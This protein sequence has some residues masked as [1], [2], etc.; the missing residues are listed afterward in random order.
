MDKKIEFWDPHFH[1]WDVRENT[2]TGQELAELFAPN[3]D[4]V[5]AIHSYEKDCDTGDDDIEPLGGAWLEALSV[6]QVGKT[7]PEYIKDCLAEYKWAAQQ[8]RKSSRNYVLV[9]TAP[10]EEPAVGGLL[11]ELAS[12]P[13]VKGIRQIVNH[14][15]DWPR[16]THLGDLL[17]NPDW[18][19]GYAE[20]QKHKLSFDLQLNP[21]QFTKAAALIKRHPEIPVI[22]NH[23]GSPTLEDLTEKSDQFRAGIESLAACENTAI[24]LSMLFYTAQDWDQHDVVMDAVWFV[25]DTFGEDRCFFATNYPVDIKFG[26]SGGR[27][28]GA[29]RKLV[30]ARYG[31]AVLRKMFSG[32]ATRIYRAGESFASRDHVSCPAGA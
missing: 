19:R 28:F 16:N 31:E 3:G 26:W 12:D 2:T 5:Y 4:P 29:M 25:I 1:I 8:V 32:N 21:H 20:L 18:Q 7:G 11:A 22:I 6:C 23:L 14:Q 9:P 15:P 13:K 10:L 27:L 24:K 17:D 30:E